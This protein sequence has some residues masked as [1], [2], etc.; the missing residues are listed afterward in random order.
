MKPRCR[1]TPPMSCT[2][3]GIISHLNRVVANGDFL[4]AQA[5]AG[6][7][8][9][10]RTP[11]AEFRRGFLF[12]FKRLAPLDFGLLGLQLAGLGHQFIVTARLAALFDARP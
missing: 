7:F 12:D 3:N 9:P 4:S 2:S 8:S 6:V 11:R 10:Q 1:P 5:A